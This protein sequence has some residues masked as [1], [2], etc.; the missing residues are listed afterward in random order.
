MSLL[1]KAAK[2]LFNA[3][4]V[5]LDKTG[6]REL[7]KWEDQPERIKDAWRKMVGEDFHDDVTPE[8]VLEMQRRANAVLGDDELVQID[9]V[10]K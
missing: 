9:P 7:P 10:Q 2:A 3:A 5:G 4:P 1:E 6:K 8:A